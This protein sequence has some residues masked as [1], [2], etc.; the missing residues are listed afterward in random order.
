MPIRPCETRV[1]GDISGHVRYGF[2]F[3]L[4]NQADGCKIEST[5]DA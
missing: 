1:S 3:P 5:P 4:L 2:S